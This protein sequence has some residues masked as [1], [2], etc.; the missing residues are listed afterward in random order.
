MDSEILLLH[1]T[2]L[3][4]LLQSEGIDVLH[5]TSILH[6]LSLLDLCKR[7]SRTLYKLLQLQLSV[8]LPGVPRERV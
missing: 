4:L 3:R 5:C 7:A 2:S 8:A 1:R 6:M